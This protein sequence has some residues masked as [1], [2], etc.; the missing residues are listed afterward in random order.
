MRDIT[1]ESTI[2]ERYGHRFAVVRIRLGDST[3]NATIVG[4]SGNE[5]VK[6]ACVNRS[7][8]DVTVTDGPCDAKIREV[9]SAPVG[10]NGG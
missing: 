3:P 9:F 5:V 8:A 2:V 7:G 10:G 6:I 4:I 1:G